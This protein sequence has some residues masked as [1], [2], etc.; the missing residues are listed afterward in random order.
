[1][2]YRKFGNT[3][4]KISALGFG[5]MRLPEIDLGDDK[6]DM[7]YDK[8]DE[9]LRRGYELGINYFD[10]APFYCH[11]NSEIAVGR[12]IKPFREKIYLS[13]KCPMDKIKNDDDFR[14]QLQSS[15]DK[16]DT[17]YVDFYHFWGINKGVFDDIILKYNLLESALKLKEEGVIRHI[18]FSFHDEP[19]NIKH[20]IDKAVV[21]GKDNSVMETMLVQYN[22]LDR[23]NEEWIDYAVSK[24]MGVVAMGPVAGG[25]LVAPKAINAQFGADEKIAEYDLAF[26]FVLDNENVT[27]ALSGMESLEMVEQNVA[28]ITGDLKLTEEDNATIER[29]RTLVSK[30]NE[31]YCTGCEYCQPCLKKI[32]IP[33][34]FAAF[35][36][37]NVYKQ[38][39]LAKEKYEQFKA[40][41]SATDTCVNCEFCEKKCPQKL[42]IRDLFNKATTTLSA[43]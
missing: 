22:L 21:S 27:C 14:K 11:H 4:I 23:K 37:E 43:L 12:G 35:T 18:S 17:D 31:L 26:R 30:F 24:G 19:Q 25:K 5:C 16:L 41:S 36:L 13:T 8:C 1:M 2:I 39:E 42:K 3:G 20:I 10:T 34:L 9:M 7:D 28:V 40:E 29:T 15:L 6:F 38:T 33:K 32:Q